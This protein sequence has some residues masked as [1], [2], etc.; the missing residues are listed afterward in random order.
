MATRADRHNNPAAFT[1]D[2]AEEAGLIAGTDYTVGDSFVTQFGTLY[3][4]KLLGDPVAL[5]VRVI[6]TIGFKTRGGNWRWAYVRMPTFAW[7][8]FS[9]GLK[10]DFIGWMYANEGGTE[11]RSLFPNYGVS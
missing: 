5:T 3:T 9:D 2:I 4:A 11:L 8:E 1:T 10:R 7:H 6:D